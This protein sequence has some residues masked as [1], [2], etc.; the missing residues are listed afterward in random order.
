[1]YALVFSVS[2]TKYHIL[3]SEC[4]DSILLKLKATTKCEVPKLMEE[5]MTSY[6]RVDVLNTINYALEGLWLFGFHQT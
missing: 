6:P 1:V 2:N 3:C 4:L 5:A